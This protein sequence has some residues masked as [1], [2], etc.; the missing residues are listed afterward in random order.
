M[1]SRQQMLDYLKQGREVTVE[2]QNVEVVFVKTELRPISHYRCARL[3]K[4]I[5]RDVALGSIYFG[6]FSDK[7]QSIN[8]GD[9]V[10]L[11]VKVTG[12]GDAT[13]KYPD[14]ILFAK[15]LTRK[16]D[17]VKVEAPAANTEEN[18]LSINI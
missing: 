7:L 13:E 5:V 8:R 12:V 4:V 17:S 3:T 10:S 16:G 9:K 1:I 6:G 2:L 15:P 11:K 18:G 14:P